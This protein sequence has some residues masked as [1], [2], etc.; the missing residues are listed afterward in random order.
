M[1]KQE[2]DAQPRDDEFSRI[3][4][5]YHARIDEITRR[6]EK[7]LKSLNTDPEEV[8]S[9][10]VERYTK[11]LPESPPVPPEES[12]PEEPEAR[13]QE[14][15]EPEA[16]EPEAEEPE[17]LPDYRTLATNRPYLGLDRRDLNRP[18]IPESTQIIREARQQA[19]KI[20]EEAEQKTRKE[21][22]KKTQS[23]V[24]KIMERAKKEAEDIVIRT[25]QS[26]EEEKNDIIN[27]SR[28]EAA[29]VIT[30][31]TEKCRQESQSKSSQAISEAREKA[32]KIMAD[33]IASSAETNRLITEI[34][35]R[36][37]QTVAEFE[38]R[39]REEV[40]DLARIINEARARLDEVATAAREDKAHSD[41]PDSNEPAEEITNPSLVVRILGERSNGKDGT[42]ALFRGQVEMKSSS[43]IDYQYLKTLKKHLV[44]IPDVKY[45]QEYASEKEMSV[46]F[47]IREPLPLLEVLRQ[48]PVV[49]DIVPGGDDG[50]VIV[51]ANSG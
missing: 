43:A 46:L 50:F 6:T 24:D 26:A 28:Q 47:D 31:I 18:P 15:E 20:V 38:A 40:G 49:E 39:L 2:T 12:P 16:E 51:F 30:E 21:A 17:A 4:S 32:Q 8:A 5:E 9:A 48:V 14:A 19:K 35:G 41:T 33:V 45:L 36:A 22:K 34:V 3:F 42:P 27:T 10:V 44:S 37:G 7:K 1:A 23:Q 11:D 13:E 29:R 25:R